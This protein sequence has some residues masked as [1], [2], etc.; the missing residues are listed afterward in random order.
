MSQYKIEE[1]TRR[2]DLDG[3]VDVIWA[4]MD[5]VNPSHRIF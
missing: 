3:I 4:A 1:V 2:E 5:G